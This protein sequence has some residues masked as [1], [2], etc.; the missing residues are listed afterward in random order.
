MKEKPIIPSE[1]TQIDRRA[2]P[3][4]KAV[5]PLK[6]ESS[7]D[8]SARLVDV[9]DKGICFSTLKPLSEKDYIV[10][11]KFPSQDITVKANIKWSRANSED[12]RVLHGATI[13]TSSKND[14]KTIR[15]YMVSRKFKSIVKGM[16]NK[17][18]RRMV[19]RFAKQYRDYLF[20]LFEISNS[21]EE[22]KIKKEEAYKSVSSLT[23]D[24]LNKGNY[25]DEV[26][27]NK[28]LMD[29]LK[30]EFRVL[31]SSWAYKSQIVKRSQD[32]PRGYPGDY[33]TL[34]IIY[35]RK[36]FSPDSEMGYYF[37]RYFLSNPYAEAVRNRKDMMREILEKLI[38]NKNSEIKILN[39]ACGSSREIRE[40]FKNNA[41]GLIKKKILL[42]CVDWDEDAL[43]FSKEKLQG[44]PN[45]V[46][47]NFIKENIMNFVKGFDLSRIDGKQD[48]IYSIGLMD[49][50]PNRLFGTLMQSLFKLLKDKG[51][52]IVAHKDISKYKP[53]P[54]NWFCDWNFYSRDKEVVLN[55]IRKNIKSDNV[56]IDITYEK[57]GV[58]FFIT[59][60]RGNRK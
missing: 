22:K 6:L 14:I 8:L 28:R 15:K 43:C 42:S 58:I 10:K 38:A 56:D 33:E 57:S 45:N 44:L 48:V 40:L 60:T 59:I 36:I 21:L 19:L 47:F 9:G 18:E 41:Q 13:S 26:I 11:M 1:G 25:L 29:K 30:H 31:T 4:I 39:I 7:E 24:I 53:L 34:E 23:D 35:D 55:L 3:R 27:N 37:D 46:K 54:P 2:L 52:L 51:Q 50:L 17:E 32:K 49:Y 20:S 5:I 12:N 16:K